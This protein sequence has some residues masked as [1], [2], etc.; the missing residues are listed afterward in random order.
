MVEDVDELG[1]LGRGRVVDIMRDQDRA[2]ARHS[3]CAGVEAL[4]EIRLV[5]HDGGSVGLRVWVVCV[6]YHCVGMQEAK[7]M[8]AATKEAKTTS[9]S[10]SGLELGALSCLAR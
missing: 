4:L 10:C 5:L 8:Y 1:L 2:K 9:V 3:E 7:Y 6:V